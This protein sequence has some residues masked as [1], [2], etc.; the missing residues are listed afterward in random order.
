MDQGFIHT[1]QPTGSSYGLHQEKGGRHHLFRTFFSLSFCLC[2]CQRVACYRES[3]QEKEGRWPWKPTVRW[4]HQPVFIFTKAWFRPIAMFCM[5]CFEQQCASNKLQTL[6]SPILSLSFCFILE[7][8]VPILL[9]SFI[10]KKLWISEC[11]YWWS[12]LKLVTQL[13]DL[14]PF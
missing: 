5:M 7:A 1:L 14:S 11:S 13:D 8:P 9:V 10:I 6:P 4:Q 12:S 2:P 3:P